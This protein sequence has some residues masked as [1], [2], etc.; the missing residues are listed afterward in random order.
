MKR[1]LLPMAFL[2]ACSVTEGTVYDKAYIAA[3]YEERS[4]ARYEY[5]CEPSLNY[6]GEVVLDCGN[7][8]AGQEHYQ[9]W[10]EDCWELR[11]KNKDGDKG[12]ECVPELVYKEMQ[13]DSYYKPEG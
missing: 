11:F 4:R 13:I 2:I 10:I 7:K 8:Y 12:E 1:A 3:H 5:R 9:V 6:E